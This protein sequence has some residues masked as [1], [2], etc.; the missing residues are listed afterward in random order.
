MDDVGAACQLAVELLLGVVRP[1]LAPVGFWESGVGEE[2]VLGAFEIGGD[3]GCD[4]LDLVDHVAVLGSGAFRVGL[5]DDRADQRGDDSA[6]LV[7]AGSTGGGL[8]TLACV[9]HC[10]GPAAGL[11]LTGRTGLPIRA[12]VESAQAAWMCRM[13]AL[14]QPR[15]LMPTSVSVPPVGP[16]TARGAPIPGR[17][18]AAG[19]G[20]QC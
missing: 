5:S 10:K 7:F 8:P 9:R 11:N 19:R 1:D 20:Q 14:P 16:P 4:R 13:N 17:R 12:G 15:A 6:V 2:V 3:G 18:E